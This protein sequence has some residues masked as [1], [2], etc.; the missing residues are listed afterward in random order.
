[1]KWLINKQRIRELERKIEQLESEN[2]RL[3]DEN[4]SAWEMLEEIKASE[5]A[6]FQDAL[7]A[8]HRDLMYERL[9][10]SPPV[11]EA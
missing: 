1:M 3:K 10:E 11:G 6:N 9:L 7:E 5:V 2:S 4:A 8:A